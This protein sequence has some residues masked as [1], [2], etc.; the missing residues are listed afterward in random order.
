MNY[1]SSIKLAAG[2]QLSGNEELGW[3]SDPLNKEDYRGQFWTTV[4]R[5][6]QTFKTQYINFNPIHLQFIY[7]YFA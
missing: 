2:P 3:G 4:R 5:V 6:F 7:Q 1:R